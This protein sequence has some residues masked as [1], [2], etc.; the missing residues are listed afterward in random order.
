MPTE[1]QSKY[2]KS[3][4]GRKRPPRS[5]DWI[6]KQSESHKGKKLSVETRLK[7]SLAHKGIKHSELHKKRVSDSKKGIKNASWKGGI[8]PINRLIRKSRDYELWRK[9]IFERDGYKCI[10]CGEGGKIHADHIKPFC[11]YP[12]LRFALDNGRTLCI[13]CHKKTDTY[14]YKIYNNKK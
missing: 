6:R 12:E 5:A 9:S 13:E 14:G 1:K 4:V 10:W 8:T 11:D 2:W 7:L 3:M